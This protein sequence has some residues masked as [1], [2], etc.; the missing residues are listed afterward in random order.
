[1]LLYLFWPVLFGTTCVFACWKRIELRSTFFV[2]TVI[3][4]F[5]IEK[6]FDYIAWRVIN[7]SASTMPE[8]Y[9]WSYIGIF[10]A[11]VLFSIG[12]VAL[13]FRMKR[14]NAT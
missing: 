9:Y 7:F 8:S 4:G 2:L 6:V 1:M 11:K 12:G 10:S 3:I 5:G 13:L 14:A